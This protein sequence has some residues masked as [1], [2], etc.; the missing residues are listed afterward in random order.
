MATIT[1]TTLDDI[2]ANDGQ[3]SLR[4]ALRM[5]NNTGQ[6]DEIVFAE[7]LSGTVTLVDGA[8]EI[9][10]DVAILGDVDGDGTGDITI[11]ASGASR[12]LSVV[13]G[14]GSLDGLTLTGGYVAGTGGGV[15]LSSGASLTVTDSQI[16]G[17]TAYG[18]AGGGIYSAGTLT[19]VNSTIDGNVALYAGGG[20]IAANGGVVSI[21]GST[22]SNN[23]VTYNG[24]GLALTGAVTTISTSSV[25]RNTA[26]GAYGG[27][28]HL[29]GGSLALNASTLSRNTASYGGGLS[30]DGEGAAMLTQATIASNTAV[31]G[32]GIYSRAGAT[33]LISSTVAANEVTGAYGGGGVYLGSGTL[34]ATN[35]IL[36]GNASSAGPAD[37]Y[38]TVS[39][40]GGN[41]IGGEISTGETV[42]GA[43]TIGGT[44][45]AVNAGLPTLRDNGGPVLTVAIRE[46]GSAEELGDGSL[47]PPDSADLDA[48]GDTAEDTPLDAAGQVRL[49]NALLDVGAFEFVRLSLA[50]SALSETLT[51]QIQGET[52][53]GRGGNDTLLGMGGDDT[54][55]GGSGGDTLDGGAGI[56]TATY[57]NANTRVRADLTG[58]LTGLGQGKDD[59]FTSI[60]NMIGSVSNDE[61]RADGGNNMLAGG[62]GADKL[63]GRGGNDV[64]LGEDG[65]DVLYGN[66]GAD[67]MTGG[68]GNNRYIYFNA[69]DSGAGSGN[70][71]I[72]A[73]FESGSDR[74]ELFR[75]DANTTN[76][77]NQVFDF[78]GTTGFS[79][80][81]GEIRFSQV[82]GSG[83]T[84][85]Q[86][87]DDGDGV[88]DFQIELT[89]LV[90]LQASDFL[91]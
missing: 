11:D 14:D 45:A 34:S 73:D 4:E 15:S 84:L 80:T 57:E 53:T 85:I 88:A 76:G 65:N 64:L 16:S 72:I 44:F 63:H 10:R 31:S 83:F 13:S 41:I 47:L 49:A 91:L 9:T 43:A 3:T 90:T 37:L 26:N 29:S 40:F 35:S 81:A 50:G 61:L 28:I 17:N 51:G 67:M 66:S 36:F 48:D 86:A 27:G 71:D 8:L 87:D 1:V 24:A 75:L 20:G 68:A 62:N 69:S 54:L 59:V 42:T 79:N 39:R 12:V 38:G 33:S 56:D 32:G 82:A 74:I 23:T 22:I 5:A 89:G 58:A 6:A 2:T 30:V 70:R 77:G 21:S 46:G 55:D 19:V 18:A 52:L 60:E 78:I 7:G 25:E